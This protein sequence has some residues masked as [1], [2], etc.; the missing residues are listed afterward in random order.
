MAR[1]AEMFAKP[2]RAA[3]RVMARLRDAGERPDGQQVALYQ[4]RCGWSSDWIVEDRPDSQM[5]RGMPC[6]TCNAPD[7]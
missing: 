3:P 4:C 5:K 1:Q 2:P 6:P 7:R